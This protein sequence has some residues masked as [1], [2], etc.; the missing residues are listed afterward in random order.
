MTATAD[1]IAATNS[2]IVDAVRTSGLN[3]DGSNDPS[4]YTVN[5]GCIC[6]IRYDDKGKA[7]Y[8][9]LCNFDAKVTEEILLDDGAEATRAFIISRGC[10]RWQCEAGRFEGSNTAVI[11]GAANAANLYTQRVAGDRREVVLPIGQH[12]GYR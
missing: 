1:T 12:S 7:T 11:T 10:E 5:G 6:K 8:E 4:P 3:G 9:P 2:D